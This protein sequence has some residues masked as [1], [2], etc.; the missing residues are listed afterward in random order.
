MTALATRIETE[1]PSRA[2]LMQIAVE[3]KGWNLWR[4]KHGYWNFD[5]PHGERVNTFTNG[6]YQFRFDPDTGD[7]NPH[8]DE[9]PYDYLWGNTNL[10]DWLADLT[11]AAGLMPEGWTVKV[12]ISHTGACEAV[13]TKTIA[14][15]LVT[16]RAV[17]PTEPRA[18]AA[19]AMRA[20]EA[21]A[22][23]G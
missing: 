5:G 2:L 6:P 11:A 13:A 15:R 23:G 21:E 3:V 4:S 1:E 12:L 16:I 19:L 8:Y 18:R 10:D 20:I 7:E 14:D 9:P 17:A 22:G